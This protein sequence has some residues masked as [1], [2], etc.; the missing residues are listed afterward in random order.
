[1]PRSLAD[2]FYSDEKNRIGS[3]VSRS[4]FF[5]SRR[6]Q[7]KRN[8]VRGMDQSAAERTCELRREGRTL[9]H[10]DN[11]RVEYICGASGGPEHRGKDCEKQNNDGR[12]E[13]S[14]TNREAMSYLT[15][16][17]REVAQR[18][19]QPGETVLTAIYAH[20]TILPA[21]R[22]RL[23]LTGYRQGHPPTR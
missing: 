9:D 7:Q 1:M 22:G 20:H 5:C 11:E 6:I 21:R 10:S 17:L 16:P 15:A 13:R 2:S 14:M 4:L 12:M 3:C 19:L 18:H 23:W 8:R